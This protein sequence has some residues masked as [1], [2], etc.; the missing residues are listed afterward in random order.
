MSAT[1]LPTGT[2]GVRLDADEAIDS[3][4]SFW[5]G[6]APAAAP[7]PEA[8]FSATLKGTIDGHETL[9]TVRGMSADAFRRNLQGIRGLLDTPAPAK[10]P[11]AQGRGQ[12]AVREDEGYC[13]VHD[14]PMRRIV[15]DGRSWLSHWCESEGRYCSGKP[16]R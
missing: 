15:K 12:D 10:Q 1:F 6:A 7:C 14:T 11:Q 13:T 8:M 16:R 9:L 4:Y 2:N 5:P 3:L